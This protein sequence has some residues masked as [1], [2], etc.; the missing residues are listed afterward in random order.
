M[1]VANPTPTPA[2]AT[3]TQF[4]LCKTLPPYIRCAFGLAAMTK[5]STMTKLRNV[6]EATAPCV[7]VKNGKFK[8][9]R[10]RSKDGLIGRVLSGLTTRL[11]ERVFSQGDLPE[12]TTR[13][14]VWRGGRWGGKS[15]GRRRGSAVDAQLTKIANT[16]RLP[17][18]PPLKL[19]SMLL[20]AFERKK[21]ALISGQRGVASVA[22]GIGTALDLVC[23]D[24]RN[25]ELV[26]IELKCGFD[27]NRMDA[28]TRSGRVLKLKPPLDA[29]CD[30]AYHRHIVQL[31]VAAN[32]FCSEDETI[33]SLKGM[34]VK[35]VR[36][37]LVYAS[38]LDVEFVQL[39]EWW[40]KRSGRV[41]SVISN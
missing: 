20:K 26:L 16:G 24:E 2:C 19:T 33:R 31:A 35:G 4:Y 14:R 40:K 17:S 39:Q 25:D 3:R 1:H 34:G 29:A 10:T 11:S 8:S 27:G 15:G 9:F 36:S 23:L 5:S 13:C 6:L 30:C 21:Y 22:H 38:D 41:L 28:V 18:N 37:E 32:M 7:L 12:S